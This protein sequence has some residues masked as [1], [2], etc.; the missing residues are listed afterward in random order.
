MSKEIIKIR[1]WIRTNGVFSEDGE[2]ITYDCKELEEIIDKALNLQVVGIELP[3]S[4]ELISDCTK[5][6]KD[7]EGKG[8]L[9]YRSY[10]SGYLD[11][12][13]KYTIS[14]KQR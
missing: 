12:F 4:T 7:L 13:S 9:D 5:R 10:R 14:N 2:S 8:N 6:F 3:T 1:D 11:S